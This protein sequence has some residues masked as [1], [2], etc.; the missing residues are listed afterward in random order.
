M[1]SLIRFSIALKT[2]SWSVRFL[3]SFLAEG[4]SAVFQVVDERLE[5]LLDDGGSDLL[6]LVRLVAADLLGGLDGLGQLALGFG[7]GRLVRLNSV[8]FGLEIFGDE[9]AIGDQGV[10][11]AGGDDGLEV[12]ADLLPPV[13]E[14]AGALEL[15]EHAQRHEL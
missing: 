5:S 13:D 11:P 14:N 6:V 7:D 3:S 2:L 8:G 15:V 1:A 4:A 9:V 10:V 12:E